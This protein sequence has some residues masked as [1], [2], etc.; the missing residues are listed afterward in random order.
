MREI[1]STNTYHQVLMIVIEDTFHIFLKF[2]SENF[3]GCYF[4]IIGT[5]YKNVDDLRST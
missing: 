3:N 5:T 4:L 2:S 1:V